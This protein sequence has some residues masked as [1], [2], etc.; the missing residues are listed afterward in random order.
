MNAT[1]LRNILIWLWNGD[2]VAE[3][4]NISKKRIWRI[5]KGAVD[6]TAREYAIIRSYIKQVRQ[7]ISKFIKQTTTNSKE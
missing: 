3:R 1:K 6:P 7:Y 4:T 2:R 5:I